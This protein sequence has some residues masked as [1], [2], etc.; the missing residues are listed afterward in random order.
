MHKLAIA[1]AV[2]VAA[3]AAAFTSPASADPGYTCAYSPRADEYV[4]VTQGGKVC[5]W[6]NDPVTGELVVTCKTQPAKR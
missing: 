3:A 6:T 5:P 2:I 1:L 4:C